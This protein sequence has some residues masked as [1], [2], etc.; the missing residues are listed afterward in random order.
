VVGIVAIR[1]SNPVLKMRRM[2]KVGVFLAILVA[3]ETPL[4]DFS[5]GSVPERKNLRFVSTAFHVRF[6][7]AV[8]I[9]RSS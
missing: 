6:A 9:P 7:G 2:P 8:A 5:R 4:A 3:I 1:A